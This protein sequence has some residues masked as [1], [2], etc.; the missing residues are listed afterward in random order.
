[1]VTN[2]V[3]QAPETVAP[4]NGLFSVAEVVNHG[5]RDEHWIG[6]YYVESDI[7]GVTVKALPLCTATDTDAIDVF[8]NS[9][10]SRF[11]HTMG[12]GIIATIECNNSIGFNAVDGRAKVVRKVVDA[13][14]YGVEQEL[15]HGNIA[16]VDADTETTND[17]W[18]ANATSVSS[19]GV[20]AKVALGLVEDAFARA[21]PGVRATI[22]ITPLIAAILGNDLDE[23]GNKFYT[24]NG[25]LVTINRGGDGKVGPVAGGSDTKHWIYAT[26]PVHVDLGSEELITV[27]A[28]EVVNASTNAVTYAAERPAAVYFDG[29]AWFGALADATL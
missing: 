9:D 24:A 25:S 29:C 12:F 20:K 22:H 15:W 16:Q 28:G 6:G 17:R 26:G 19:S 10:G 14:E 8:D 23:D 4:L 1:M 3:S 27:S 13:T 7:C 11:F 2:G 21:N 18:L 5:S